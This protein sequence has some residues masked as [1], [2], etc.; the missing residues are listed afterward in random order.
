VSGAV[1]PFAA[2][3][4][5]VSYVPSDYTVLQSVVIDSGKPD[6]QGGAVEQKTGTANGPRVLFLGS[7]PP[8]RCGLATFLDDVT[9]NYPGPHSVIAVDENSPQA[10]ERVYPDKVIFRLNETIRDA[11]YRVAEMAN[12]GAYDVVNIQHEYGLFGGMAG[13][14][15]IALIGAIRKPVIITMHT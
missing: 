15:V 4:P 7:Y 1:D 2:P 14:Y 6:Y 12:S 13:E 5:K 11:Y 10:R 8:R 3:Y 9:E